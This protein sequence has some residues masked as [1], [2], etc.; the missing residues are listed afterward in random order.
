MSNEQIHREIKKLENLISN[1]SD[2]NEIKLFTKLINNLKNQN[3]M[4]KAEQLK[5][6]QDK[7]AKA[8]K[9]LENAEKSKNEQAVGIMK[10]TIG[11]IEK[12]IKEKESEEEKAAEPEKPAKEKKQVKEK[13]VKEPKVKKEKKKTKA[14]KKAERE[15]KKEAKKPV[16]TK[17]VHAVT[18][19]P[20]EKMTCKELKE[21]ARKRREKRNKDASKKTKPVL[22][23]VAD[24]VEEAITSAIFYNKQKK[25][26]NIPKLKIAVDA[27]VEALDDL[28]DALA[29]KFESTHIDSFKKDMYSIL[30]A[31][32]KKE[33]ED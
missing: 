21:W 3:T 24:H 19:K 22:M 31:L 15:A 16:K 11:K 23:R 6:L 12:A 10:S 18:K 26:L 9:A 25:E 13:K 33:K 14:Q 28:K 1:T 32:K 17:K 30:D 5:E 27:F 29:G 7:L 4:T 8:T 20:L 2:K